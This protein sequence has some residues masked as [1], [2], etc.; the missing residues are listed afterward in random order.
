MNNEPKSECS[1][2]KKGLNRKY[3]P[4]IGIVFIMSGGLI[5]GTVKLISSIIT[6][7]TH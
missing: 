6:Y 5:Y 4:V 7:F 3:Y 2:C 1:V